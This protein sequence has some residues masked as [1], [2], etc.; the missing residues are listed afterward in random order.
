MGMKW[1]GFA[2]EIAWLIVRMAK[3]SSVA[4]RR[5]HDAVIGPWV[6]THG[7]HQMSLRD[8]CEQAIMLHEEFTACPV[9]LRGY[10]TVS[11]TMNTDM[12]CPRVPPGLPIFPKI[13][14]LFVR[15]SFVFQRRP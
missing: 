6:E 11:I 12:A 5:H 2:I 14:V 13:F 15:D 4:T 7:Y 3:R 9:L 1:I 10:Q 8:I